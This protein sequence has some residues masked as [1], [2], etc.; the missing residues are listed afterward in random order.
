MKPKYNHLAILT[1]T[2]LCQSTA[3]QAQDNESGE[4]VLEEILVTATKR[5]TSEMQVP[6]SMEVVSG[7]VILNE[8]ID[9]P[10]D[11]AVR[12]PNVVMGEGLQSNTLY[13]RGMG[14]GSERS[15]EQSVAMFV[16]G[17]YM[18]R[19]RQYSG[20]FLD[21]ER[22]EVLRGPQAVLFGLNATAGAIKVHTRSNRGGDEFEAS[23]T[24]AYE[25]EYSGYSGQV[26]IGGGLSD[27]LGMRL[28]VSYSDN[29]DG[30][31]YNAYTDKRENFKKD[32][33]ARLSVV[34]NASDDLMFTGKVTVVDSD[35][36][37]NF[38][39]LVAS[40]AG[41][42]T[43]AALGWSVDSAF[44]WV[45]YEDPVPS[46]Y[47]PGEPGFVHDMTNIS[48]ESEY[49]LDNH[50]LTAVLGHTT[51]D[52]M[53]HGNV[54]IIATDP[55]A[56]GA[57]F[58]FVQFYNHVLTNVIEE[59]YEQTSL[60]VRLESSMDGQFSYIVGAYI[61]DSKLYNLLS[62]FSGALFGGPS[63]GA[64][65]MVS[66]MW[67]VSNAETL[68]AFASMTY[69]F[70]D[71]FRIIGGAR[72]VKLDKDYFRDNNDCAALLY[73]NDGTY[74]A[75]ADLTGS[76]LDNC[77]TFPG[78]SLDRSPGNFMPEVIAQWD[79]SDNSQLY[80]KVARSAKSGGFNF[81]STLAEADQAEYDDEKATGYEIGLK[82]RFLGGRAELQLAAFFTEFEDLQ[83]TSWIAV[84]GQPTIGVLG[85]AAA[86]ESK[87]LEAELNFVV[88]DWLTMGAN[89][90][91][92]SSE[93]TSYHSGPCNQQDTQVTDCDR[94]GDDTPFSP[95]YSGSAYFDLNVPLTNSLNLVGGARVNFSDSY[96]TE[97][98][99]DL[100]GVQDAY[101]T[102][103]ARLG[104]A[105]SDGRWMVSAIGKNL[106]NEA[107][108]TATTPFL[109]MIGYIRPP[110]TITLQATVNF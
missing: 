38:G 27:T 76:G 29:G 98:S 68:S 60:E 94:T 36:S 79:I 59:E 31:Y 48:L 105:S 42:P 28:A 91:L 69:D 78:L 55:D 25:T 8:L 57:A 15:F 95:K 73:N 17:V 106:G 41:L 93:Y 67:Q 20:A 33:V 46:D 89:L 23:V 22:V 3:I 102:F 6:V 39:E 75:V 108:L 19:S 37:G 80:G 9:D 1:F 7:D 35:E 83:V 72:Y 107:V 56:T 49:T 21:L 103:D 50:T 100:L 11:I 71:S 44:D 51:S 110:K 40:E 99:I 92:L 24:G 34:W 86:S 10:L 54:D 64:H 45:R 58:P 26:T 61:D 2:C 90:G 65:A 104:L 16:D 5:V 96:F 53:S 63:G 12:V 18:P 74:T 109:G 101:E 81:S 97:G 4:L 66:D 77:G 88:T 62:A 43:F 13:I 84:P 82:S 32:T 14:S 30:Y 87:G 52:Y 47:L 85:N 70:S